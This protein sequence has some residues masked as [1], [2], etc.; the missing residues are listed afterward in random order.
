MLDQ[1][2]YGCSLV[3]ILVVFPIALYGAYRENQAAWS[4][5]EGDRLSGEGKHAEAAN[6]F[7][8]ALSWNDRLWS[9]LRAGRAWW[10]GREHPDC[11]VLYRIANAHELEAVRSILRDVP[12]E[13]DLDRSYRALAR[14]NSRFGI[15]NQADT[16]AT[17]LRY[18]AAL[19]RARTHFENRETETVD[20]LVQELREPP[21]ELEIGPYLR[22]RVLSLV[23]MRKYDS[24]SD[25]VYL[26]LALDMI[27]E[28]FAIK[29]DDPVAEKLHGEIEKR[30]GALIGTGKDLSLP[31]ETD[32]ALLFGDETDSVEFAAAGGTLPVG[33]TNT[34]TP[35]SLA[36][37]TAPVSL[38]TGT[39]PTILVPIPR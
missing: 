31:G 36:A 33:F 15:T 11:L 23:F 19:D 26:R 22:N 30:A 17:E 8:G 13:V 10:Q 20:L 6:V 18:L 39:A 25:P 9:T 34:T 5:A 2:R 14:A 7:E 38:T 28:G 1:L 35:V 4:I 21:D 12:A 27:E 37:S 24:S 3:L 32:E 16:I 29:T